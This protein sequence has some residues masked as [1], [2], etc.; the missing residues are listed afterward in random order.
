MSDL[1]LLWLRRDLRLNDH[2]A[3]NAA[4]DRGACVLPVFIFDPA[5]LRGP[6][7]SPTRLAFLLAGLESLD[8]RLREFRSRLIVRTGEPA[9]VLREVLDQS[10]AV[11]VH[12]TRD[13]SPFA[14]ARDARVSAALPVPL[15]LFD[16]ALIHPPEAVSKA[17]GS[18]Y[19]VFTPFY[20][21][22]SALP[23]PAPDERRLRADD[24]ADAPAVTS[25]PLPSLSEIG[26]ATSVELPKAGEAAARRL[27]TDFA[28][29][30]IFAY[31][32]GRNML[33]GP[34]WRDANAGTSALSPYLRFGM[35]SPRQALAAAQA[36]RERA[37][38]PEALKGADHWVSELAWREFYAHIL[39]H[40]PHVLRRPF[41][42][43]FERIDW[44]ASA[45]ELQRWQA[46]MTGFPVV[47][48]AMRQLAATGW[49]H[50]RARMIV[51]S[52]LTKDLLHYWSEGEAY[53]MQHLLDGDPASN[54]GGWQWTAGTGTDA[55]PFF[56]IFN[57]MLQSQRYDPDGA[58]I[59]TWVPELRAVPAPFIHAP[60]EMP[61]P[62][63]T[64][65]PPML[66]HH[67]A[68]DRALAALTAAGETA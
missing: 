3:L 47:D 10:G 67:A 50:N 30:P 55:Q 61:D 16:D 24:F 38:S 36:A 25:D 12:A 48:A 51:A 35:L 62:P 32:D 23:V 53:F 59:R 46:G 49:M 31:A 26:H 68:R 40:F 19:T 58:Y 34:P 37:Q 66:D 57:P 6:H 39:A 41:K 7:F 15:R 20:R 63:R 18:A 43:Q 56:R 21:A 28:A 42:P 17:D 1:I 4:L 2:T 11:A 60:W 52:F 64:Y 65:P 8:K 29:R 45:D 27:L 9:F 33:S 22:W 13:Y 5:L 44:R 14:N 54:N